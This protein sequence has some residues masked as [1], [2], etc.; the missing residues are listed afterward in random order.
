MHSGSTEKIQRGQKES[1]PP[2]GGGRG[3]GAAFRRARR[4]GKRK[5][6]KF[7]LSNFSRCA[8]YLVNTYSGSSMPEASKSLFVNELLQNQRRLYGF[9]L[10]I[11]ADP[12]EADDLF[13]ETAAK[14]WQIADEY[15]VSRPFMPWACAVAFNVIR[16]SQSRRR[17]DRHIFSD[18]LMREL[19]DAAVEETIWLDDRRKAL[20]DCLA[21]LSD[22][23][24]RSINLCYDGQ[25]T[26]QQVADSL[27]QNR[28]GFYKKIQRIRRA[29]MDCVN[30]SL[31]AEAQQ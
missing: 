13:Q 19:A 7:H 31:S 28:E 17:R 10:T 25:H 12:N 22:E 3:V 4:P 2:G 5:L 16:N 24:R 18:G 1:S 6:F 30:R 14:L 23:Q 11:V 21:V 20:A 26:L 15:D 27:G 29:L 9:V 8:P